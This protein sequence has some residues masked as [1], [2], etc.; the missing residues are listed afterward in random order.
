MEVHL[1]RL[2]SWCPCQLLLLA[3][4]P[5]SLVLP[6]KLLAKLA[7]ERKRCNRILMSEPCAG[8]ELLGP[9]CL[10]RMG[11]FSH[12]P[13]LGSP[14]GQKGL[15][16]RR[17]GAQPW[18]RSSSSLSHWLVSRLLDALR[19]PPVH[20]ERC[21][22]WTTF[23]GEDGEG[24]P[25][26]GDEAADILSRCSS[27]RAGVPVPFTVCLHDFRFVILSSQDRKPGLL[28]R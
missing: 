9:G 25:L 15:R 6:E 24:A 13:T 14:G 17:R 11:S 3:L 8:R 21:S 22:H 2:V 23:C 28:Q 26:P 1:Q 16:P 27:C 18:L 4:I 19:G 7:L 10:L 20:R 12:L 5:I